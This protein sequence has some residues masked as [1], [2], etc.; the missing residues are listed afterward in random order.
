MESA[1]EST[2]TLLRAPAAAGKTEAALHSLRAP[3]RGQAI[4]LLPDG[5]HV[6]R[7]MPRIQDAHVHVLQFHGLARMIL[8][9]ERAPQ[10][11]TATM[12]RMLLRDILAASVEEQAL[13][14]FARIARKPGFIATL[15]DLLFE[16]QNAEVVPRDLAAAG[17][18]PYDAELGAL[19]ARYLAELERRNLADVPRRLALAR[20]ALSADHRRFAN[21]ALLVVDGFDQ[22]TSLQLSLLTAASRQVGRMLITLTGEQNERP[23]HRRFERTYRQLVAA[24]NPV[25]EDRAVEYAIAPPLALL[26][27]CLFVLDEPTPVD[28][29]GALMVINAPDREREI[30]A[31]LR[32]ARR[33]IRAGVAPDQIALLFRDGAGYGPL[34][35]EVAAEYAVPLTLVEGL[36][37]LDA[38]PIIAIRM[39]LRLPLEDYPRRALVEVWRTLSDWGWEHVA[40]PPNA[41]PTFDLAQAARLLDQAA[42]AAGVAT[43]LSRLRGCLQ[44]LIEAEPPADYEELDLPLLKPTVAAEL[45]ARLDAFVAWLTPPPRATLAAY[46][47]RLRERVASPDDPMQR[48]GDETSASLLEQPQAVETA[49]PWQEVRADW[50]RALDD[51]VNAY[52]TLATAPI[53][54]A[55][56]V[57]ELTTTL[58]GRRYLNESPAP[59]K[60][61]ALSVL[62]ARG[63]HWDHVCLLGLA[64]G[65]FPPKP[66]DPP[67]Y[68]RRERAELA[69]RS[70]NL[71]PP[72]PADERSYFYEAVTRARRSLTLSYT[73]LDSSGNELPASS[74]LKSLLAWMQPASYP[75]HAIKAGSVPTADED[76]SPQERLMALM[77][78]SADHPS[79]PSADADIDGALLAHIRRACEIERRR[80]DARTDYG[81]FEGALNDNAVIAEMAHAFGPGRRWSVTQ[82]NDYITCPF[83][84]AATHVLKLQPRAEPEEGLVS[85]GRGRMYHAILAIAGRAWIAHELA[86]T[87]DN[88]DAIIAVLEAATDEVLAEAPTTFG[89]APDAFWEW[90]QQ[91]IRRRLQQAVRRIINTGG[92]WAD[93][94][95]AAIEKSFG[96]KS[97]D[98]PLVITTPAGDVRVCGRIDRI[99]QRDGDK[100]LAVLDYKSSSAPRTLNETVEARDVQLMVYVL[101]AEALF[102][103]PGQSVDRAAFVHL[104]SGKLSKPLTGA[105][106]ESADAALRAR[107]AEIVDQTRAGDFSVRPRDDCPSGCAFQGICRLSIRKRDHHL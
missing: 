10:E 93:F 38:P 86:P 14:A 25:V 74:Y 4:L 64:D 76:A 55:E 54:Y 99:D 87:A 47:G 81:P 39:L 16:A 106:R 50:D 46:A 91:N 20:D 19:Y 7:I 41:A 92:D 58:S 80:E 34:L 5:L 89:F 84:F 103:A 43:G 24:L 98:P 51:L 48:D 17:V 63:S 68:S 8:G 102:A 60:V 53:T 75:T 67:L 105:D 107:I 61:A 85:A 77:E 11:L 96:L 44:R 13:P 78:A 59:G 100:A 69:R 31:V 40:Q 3:R 62:T 6:E 22:F 88:A 66:T 65:E 32:Q 42:R 27:R 104:G 73:R 94:R 26:E 72:D 97:G 30:R 101:A 71:T 36:P 28:A 57:T 18:T 37:L 70:V 45:L 2:I 95:P 56:F 79:A 49:A 35:R 33:R 21:V 23:A 1:A 15:S 82:L 9:G 29:Q 52:A 12:K 83:R 90:D